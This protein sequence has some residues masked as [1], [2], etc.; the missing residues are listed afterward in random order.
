MGIQNPVLRQGLGGGECSQDG[1]LGP[2]SNRGFSGLCCC[3]GSC[4]TQRGTGLT[5]LC[6]GS[7]RSWICLIGALGL[8]KGVWDFGRRRIKG[9]SRIYS[10]GV[11]GL[12]KGCKAYI[13]WGCLKY[14]ENGNMIISLS[15]ARK[16]DFSFGFL[17]FVI[18]LQDQN[19]GF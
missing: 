12:G 4:S 1:G 6:G 10:G 16:S 2:L 7:G 15:R 14:L 19:I 11:S 3:S 8:Y 17:V 13:Y 9:F 5:G 18:I